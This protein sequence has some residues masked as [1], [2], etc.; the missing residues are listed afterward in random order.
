MEFHGSLAVHVI[1]NRHYGS[2][3]YASYYAETDPVSRTDQ[4]GGGLDIPFHSFHTY[5]SRDCRQLKRVLE[6]G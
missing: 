6:G 1:L 5:N 2:C 3:L 4:Q